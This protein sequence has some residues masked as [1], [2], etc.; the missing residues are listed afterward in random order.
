MNEIPVIVFLSTNITLLY[1][2]AFCFKFSVNLL[3]CQTFIIHIQL[4]FKSPLIQAGSLT[5]SAMAYTAHSS[6]KE[7]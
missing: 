1:F 4:H 2:T 7:L 6:L 5:R 3:C